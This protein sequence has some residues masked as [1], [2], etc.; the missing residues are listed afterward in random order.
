MCRL[1]V[2]QIQFWSDGDNFHRNMGIHSYFR[3]TLQNGQMP[4]SAVKENPLSRLRLQADRLPCL[5]FIS[6]HREIG[7]H[8][9]FQI[10]VRQLSLPVPQW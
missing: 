10:I 5:A 6:D 7:A 9:N 3:M 2:R 4:H 1:L 8:L